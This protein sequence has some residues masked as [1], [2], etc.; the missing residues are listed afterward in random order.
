MVRERK[1][2]HLIYQ[3]PWQPKYVGADAGLGGAE[4]LQDRPWTQNPMDTDKFRKSSIRPIQ[5][6]SISRALS[7]AW[8]KGV[9][10]HQGLW[11]MIVQHCCLLSRLSKKHLFF[12]PGPTSSVTQQRKC[13][14]GSG[15]TFL[16]PTD[17]S[18]AIP[19][20]PWFSF[21][22]KQQK[23][24]LQSCS[25][26]T[27]RGSDILLLPDVH[28]DLLHHNAEVL[29]LAKNMRNH[30]YLWQHN[31]TALDLLTISLLCGT[32]DSLSIWTIIRVC[33]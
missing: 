32:G 22:W 9:T 13:S 15:T 16:L 18:W 20:Y 11:W 14:R 23:M 12:L 28:H 6:K 31:D 30:A 1:W 4:F 21:H 5:W 10:N 26:A 19:S 17:T 25:D 3:H 24:R 27:L 2:M 7:Y 29:Y 8:C 33:A